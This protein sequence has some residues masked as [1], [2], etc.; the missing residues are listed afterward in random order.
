MHAV[1]KNTFLT[2]LT[3]RF[4]D[5]S[6][7]DEEPMNVIVQYESLIAALLCPGRF[8]LFDNNHQRN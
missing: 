7:S 3:T 5:D 4:R 8:V 1:A 2:A 6:S